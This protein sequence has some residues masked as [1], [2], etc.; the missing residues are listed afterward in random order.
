[1]YPLAAFIAYVLLI[2]GAVAGYSARVYLS[3][4][5]R[6]LYPRSPLSNGVRMNANMLSNF[7]ITQPGCLRVLQCCLYSS[8]LVFI[9]PPKSMRLICSEAEPLRSESS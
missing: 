8:L 2:C 5:D 6:W 9:R 4:S 1:M 3:E 7:A